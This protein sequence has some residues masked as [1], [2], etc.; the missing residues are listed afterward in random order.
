LDRSGSMMSKGKLSCAKEAIVKVIEGL[1]DRD[2]MSFVVY[3]SDVTTIFENQHLT[4]ENK[5][6]LIPQVNQVQTSGMTN[7]WGGLEQGARLVTQHAEKGF[8]KRV[9]LFSDGLVNEGVKDKKKILDM[10]AAEIYKE[11][12]VKVSAF[13][14]GDDFDE[15]LMKGIAEQGSGAYF[16]IE[17][18]SAIPQ[19]TSFALK[20]LFKLVGSDALLTLRGRNGGVVKKIYGHSDLLQPYKLDDLIQD[21]ERKVICDL[22]VTPTASKDSEE[23]LHY[24][25][26]Y[27]PASS[28]DGTR[29][30]VTGTVTM[31]FVDN[32]DDIVKN[33]ETFVQVVIQQ[34]AEIDTELVAL[35]D[36]EKLEETLALQEKQIVLFKSILELDEGGT[37]KVAALLKQAEAA[38][39]KIQLVLSEEALSSVPISKLKLWMK[40]NGVS[41]AGLV[42]KGDLIE[43][44]LQSQAKE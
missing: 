18:S 34:T 16:F 39:A 8:T 41:L 25:L 1:T 7:L 9:F 5:S 32:V 44:I 4:P 11:Q 2:V 30:S 13:G 21:N 15:E 19:F 23:V 37:N 29:T 35:M 24:E 38:E 20:G 28:T 6:K 40:Q 10:T 3:G 17:G 31:T 12:D 26:S 42:E 22:D 33:N 14:L 36:S 27:R 43:A